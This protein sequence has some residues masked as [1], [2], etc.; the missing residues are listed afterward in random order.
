[1]KSKLSGLFC[2]LVISLAFAHGVRAQLMTPHYSV[3]QSI[4]SNST[5]TIIYTTTQVSG[6][7][8]VNIGL[9][10]GTT[11]QPIATTNF[12]ASSHWTYGNPVC[13]SC[14]LSAIDNNS[15]NVTDGTVYDFSS[16]GEVQ[17]SIAGILFSSVVSNYV[18]IA[19]TWSHK[20]APPTWDSVFGGWKTLLEPY[21]D[22]A[23][24]PPDFNPPWA[25]TY[26]Q[27]DYFIGSTYCVRAGSGHPWHCG[28]GVVQ[29]ANTPSKPQACTKN[30]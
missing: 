26:A 9:P 18:E 14:S 10:P 15:W 30:P 22:A 8:K 19:K 29:T 20:T 6:Y 21:C 28:P 1:M 16:T 11:H 17:C 24:S 5:G 7:A 4:S 12:S 27:S 3:Y 13:A 25:D 23:H 2:C